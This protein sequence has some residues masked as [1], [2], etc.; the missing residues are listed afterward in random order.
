MLIPKQLKVDTENNILAEDGYRNLINSL[1]NSK[2]IS[3][4]L[5]L[6]LTKIKN[7]LDNLKAKGE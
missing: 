6:T 5:T 4:E 3:L 2:N 7:R 1:F